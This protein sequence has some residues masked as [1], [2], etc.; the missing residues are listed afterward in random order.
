LRRD[1]SCR[2]VLRRRIAQ[3]RRHRRSLLFHCS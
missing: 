1:G 3:P 2:P